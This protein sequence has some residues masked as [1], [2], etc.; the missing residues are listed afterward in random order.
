MI[1]KL[2]ENGKFSKQCKS[3]LFL[4]KILK[5]LTIYTK[6]HNIEIMIGNK[7]DEIIEKLFESLLQIFQNNLEEPMRRSKFVRDSID[8]LYYQLHKIGLKRGGL[9]IDSPEWF[10]NKKATINP[11]NNDDNC[12]L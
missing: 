3:V 6:T 1:I 12:M 7:T 8:L 11:E 2:E 5:K 10:K 9:Y 4:L